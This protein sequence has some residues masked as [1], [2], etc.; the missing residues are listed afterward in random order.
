VILEDPEWKLETYS[1]AGLGRSADN[2]YP[3]STLAAIMARPVKDIAAEDCAWFCWATVPMLPQAIALME[4]RDFTYKCHWVWD[5]ADAGTGFWSRNQH[6]ILLLG[7]RSFGRRRTAKSPTG[8][9]S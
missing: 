3:T 1:E 5:K 2:H 8:A 4:A 6:E 7:T 9:M